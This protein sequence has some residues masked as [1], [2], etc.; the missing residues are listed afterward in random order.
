MAKANDT[1]NVL[2]HQPIEKLSDNLW[3]V[4]GDLPN[5]PLKRVMTIAKQSDGG[6]VIHN[7]MALDEASMR[8]IE[9]WGEPRTLVVPNGFHRL[10]APAFVK[11][12]P[13]LKVI[14]PSGA[15]KK[16]EE[17]VKVG[18]TYEDFRDTDVKLEMVAGVADEGVMSVRSS[19]GTTLVFNDLV[20]NM[21]HVPGLQGFVLKHLTASSGGPKV[22]RVGK[23]FLIKDTRAFAGELDRLS[24][25]GDLRRVIVSHHEV[26]ETN[27]AE[28]L[29]AV[30]ASL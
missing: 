8:E 29:R 27:A 21:P 23:W 15:R 5:M 11:R 12:Y 17:V 9:A 13:S 6:L 7:A 3:R 4:Q 10:D 28:T 22:S 30:A 26:I 14:A 16:V 1:W 2:P 25:I 24:N 19:D 20:F 18:G